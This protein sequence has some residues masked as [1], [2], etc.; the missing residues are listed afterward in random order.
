MQATRCSMATRN[1]FS[2]KKTAS[3]G[4]SLMGKAMPKARN[5]SKGLSASQR[6]MIEAAK[7]Y[8][9]NVDK[10]LG[11]KLADKGGKGGGV[12]VKSLD[13]GGNAAKAGLKVGDQV[14]YHSSFFGDELWPADSLGFTNTAIKACPDDVDFI[15]VRGADIGTVDV[16]RIPKRPKLAKFGRKLTAAQKPFAEQPNTYI[17]PQCQAPKARFAEY[18][19]ITGK[20][21]SIGVPPSVLISFIIGILGF[22]AFAV[23]G[24]DL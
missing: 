12:L 2:V 15:V 19:P 24:F 4:S 13:N 8:E 6:L 22:A 17:C 10:P 9:F 7:E 20:V 1:G 3:K 23:V 5:Q 14:I 16:K 21:K 11:I 18:D